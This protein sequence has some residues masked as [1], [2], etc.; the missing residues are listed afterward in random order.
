MRYL[1]QQPSV[2][3]FKMTEPHVLKWIEEVKH[4]NVNAF[5]NLVLAYQNK[6]YSFVFNMVRNQ[7]DAEEL[8]QDVFVKV[9]RKLHLF[10]GDAKFSTWIFSIA[11]N[12]VAS[13]FRK[14]QLATTS[15]DDYKTANSI[16]EDVDN[17]FDTL[18]LQERNDCIARALEL[19][20]PQQKLLIQLFYLE[21][22]SLKEIETITGLNN[23]SIK[24]GL[25]R[26]RNRL[27]SILENTMNFKENHAS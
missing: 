25:M 3:L 26:A 18:S 19:L 10:R 15:V 1:L 17:A 21:E 2:L 16:F 11:H 27:Y 20:A 4:G 5:E 13:S 12:T 7:M 23:G 14:K 24:T 22:Q 9:Y 6:V 8:T